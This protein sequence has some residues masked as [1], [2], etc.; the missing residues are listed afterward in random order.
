MGGKTIFSDC[1]HGIY[2][3]TAGAGT[4][5]RLDQRRWQ[6]VHKP[7]IGAGPL[8]EMFQRI[9]YRIKG[10]AGT[11]H[12]DRHQHSHQVRDNADRRVESAFCPLHKCIKN[13]N[14]PVQRYP[15]D[16][17]KDKEDQPTA[18]R[19]GKRLDAVR[20]QSP[21]IE[22][23][24]GDQNGQAPDPS[25]DSRLNRLIRCRKATTLI[26]ASVV[27]KV[28]ITI[29]TNTSVGSAAPAAALI[30]ITLTGINCNPD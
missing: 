4:G 22:D 2:Q 9:D 19:A 29:G 14:L 6:P 5:Q 10:S 27:R 13:I 30:A 20:V 24:Y 16:R 21:Q 12:A 8:K 1:F 17:Q 28:A 26:E 18:E 7:G 3:H 25:Q 15:H 11:E 23:K